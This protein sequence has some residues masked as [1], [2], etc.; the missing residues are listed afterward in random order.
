MASTFIFVHG[1][2]GSP[3]ELVPVISHLEARGHRVINVDLPI[4]RAES[5]LD[6]YA[7]AVVLAMEGCERPR[8][9]VAH[10]AGGVTIPLV[11]ARVPV[12]HLIFV[13]AFVPEPGRSLAEVAGADIMSTLE[14]VTIDHGDGT[15]SFNLDLLASLA[16]PEERQ[17]YLQFLQATQRRQGWL[18]INQPWPGAGIPDVPRSYVLCTEDA[19]LPPAR[20]R[21]FASGLGVAPIEI[22]AAHSVFSTKPRELAGILASLAS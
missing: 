12:D 17:V 22:A 20:Q 14:P 5:T 4:E 13:T 8:I 2:F 3:S 9:L 7:A 18:A 10:S 15:R 6:D 19:I 16:P 11:A 21:E 1:G